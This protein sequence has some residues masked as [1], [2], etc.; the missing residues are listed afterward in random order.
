M[1]CITNT[2]SIPRIIHQTWHS[3]TYEDGQGT[4]ESWQALNPDWQY[5]L[6]LDA[7]LE[8][9]V[10]EQYP[11]L[12]GLYRDYP[13]A[14]QRADLG[15]YLLLHHFGGIYADMDT[16]CLAPLDALA[17][18]RRIV[19]CEEPRA[20]WPALAPLGLE[21]LLFNGTMASPAGH[22][23]WLHLAQMAWRS[24]HA[25][26]KN[27]LLSTGPVLL[28]A[29]VERWSVP[30]DFS[31]NSC[32]LFAPVDS[33]GRPAEDPMSGDLAALRLSRH[34]WAG[35]WFS[36]VP[37]TRFSRLKGRL[38]R[39]RVARQSPVPPLGP[40]ALE[41]LDL[42]QLKARPPADELPQIAIFTPLR[43]AEPFLKDHWALIEALDWPKDKL[44]LV[45][46]EGE[47]RDDTRSR[48]QAFQ[49]ARAADFA[50]IEILGHDTG[51]DLPRAERWRPRHQF[52]R[53][54]A[55]AS[56]RNHLI[57][58]GLSDGDDWVL[59][60]DVDVCAAPDDLLQQLL[61]AKAKIVT[62]DCVLTP[63]GP[64]YDMN[65][66]LDY[67]RPRD[68]EYYKYFLDGLFQPP[69]NYEHRLHLHDLRF[70]E[71]V[72]LTSV[73]GTVLLVH[74]SVHRAGL[75]FAE[76]PYKGLIETE[77]F[78]RMAHDAGVPP[79]GLPNIEVRHVQS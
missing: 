50:G 24:R 70:A 7:D 77:A 32:H 74:G 9:F 47:S 17:E 57:G 1:T 30:E 14:V 61:A 5:R 64:S 40:E 55:L 18:Q 69:A 41:A 26:R 19:L 28:T 33:H 39:A 56:V 63:G 53:R 23:F 54:A 21:R 44:R 20:N 58:K 75:G 8:A 52:R 65:A 13:T 16:D 43:D 37:E 51:L 15:R 11:D 4:P 45:Y 6:W 25:A 48:L 71:R 68:S 27:V 2:Q 79:V 67:G 72:E 12:I 35:N 76:R 42:A 31:M 29:A 60:L 10:A 34:N 22:P 78:G 46:C 38:R 59:W 62:P 73:G 49:K 36:E 66:S 3:P